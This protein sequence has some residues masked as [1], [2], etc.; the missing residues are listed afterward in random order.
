MTSSSSPL[1][2]T[3]AAV[4]EHDRC[5]DGD[6][7][8]EK[9][10][11]EERASPGLARV[12]RYKSLLR[13]PKPPPSSD[14]DD[15]D[16]D[17]GVSPWAKAQMSESPVLLPSLKFHDLVFGRTLG[18]GAFGV[19]R[20]ARLIRRDRTRSFWPEFAVKVIS[21]RK[22]EELG[23]SK[24]VNREI[25]I[26]RTLSHPSI[27]RLVSS[28]RFRDG[29]YLVLE[30]ASGGD[31]HTLLRRN[32]SL[33]HDSTKFVIGEVVGALWSVH[34]SGFVYGDLKPENVLIAETGHVK[35]TDF[36]ASRPVTE[37]ARELVEV[38]G[39]NALRDLRDGDWR[40]SGSPSA[41][42]GGTGGDEEMREGG[43]AEEE[44]EEEDGRIE[45]TAA[46]LPP[47]VVAGNRPSVAADAWALGC[48]L[49][50]CLS[51]R[52][53]LLE[54]TE[55]ETMR[56]IVTFELPETDGGGGGGGGG[57]D[58][59]RGGEP[60]FG[61]AGAS[62]SS[63]AFRPEAERLVRRLLRRD[64]NDRPGMASVTEDEFFGGTDVLGLHAGPALP[65]D[66][67]SV[68]PAA[69]DARW[70]RRQF[71][72]IWAPQ[73]K[74]YALGSS[75]VGGFASGGGRDSWREA[76]IPE[77]KEA[78]AHFFASHMISSL[79]KIRE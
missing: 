28:F 65:L 10:E 32:G 47:E 21:T 54:D 34:E 53:P 22:I 43:E 12:R 38:S 51:G 37:A 66:V 74:D 8:R 36:G 14:E 56:R 31:L 55:E 68:E 45:G 44:E 48:V 72:S 23:Y 58:D 63:T 71:S 69:A 42:P 9:E 62:S 75:S 15:A 59:G 40:D 73:P 67:G 1:P 60:F 7:G 57:A 11:E 50:Q 25:A 16:D 46:Y 39:R 35:L 26:L 29:A 24:S 3:V 20:Y 19:V 30:Y 79:T 64:P 5:D 4:A 41:K 13:P 70:S 49:Y 2:T 77:G 27:A 6:D 33:D 52:P 76:P 18:E 61:R 78:E 17:D